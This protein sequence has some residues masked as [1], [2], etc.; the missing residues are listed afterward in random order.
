MSR[1]AHLFIRDDIKDLQQA[2]GPFID[3]QRVLFV[4]ILP[5]IHSRVRFFWKEGNYPMLRKFCLYAAIALGL[6][7]PVQSQ[8]QQVVDVIFSAPQYVFM[9]HSLDDMTWIAEGVDQDVR[10]GKQRRDSLRVGTPPRCDF[11]KNSSNQYTLISSY[12]DIEMLSSVPTFGDS[13]NYVELGIYRA[14]DLAGNAMY[15]MLGFEVSNG[16]DIG[17]VEFLT[18]IYG[19]K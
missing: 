16:Q 1:S 8:A 18:H 12:S 3:C 4:F 6:G 17:A 7:L 15:M 13:V 2:A 11:I 5:R 19:T 9:C 10:I 14:Y